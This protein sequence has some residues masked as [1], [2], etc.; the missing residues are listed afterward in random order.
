MKK[1]IGQQPSVE[2]YCDNTLGHD[3]QKLLSQGIPITVMHGFGSPYD[4]FPDED[5]ATW[6]FCS[7]VCCRDWFNR[8][9]EA[10]PEE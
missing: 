2:Y 4:A 10:R 8:A 3:A 6:H 9:V 7:L 5:A 1:I